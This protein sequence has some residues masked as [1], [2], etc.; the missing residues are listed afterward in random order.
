MGR[1]VSIFRRR[2]EAFPRC[3]EYRHAKE[4]GY[5]PYSKTI[6]SAYRPRIRL[7]G[8]KVI[9]FGSNNYLSLSIRTA[10]GPRILESGAFVVFASMSVGDGPALSGCLP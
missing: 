4:L 9:N 10:P 5:W 2:L 7:E 1:E 8:H 6:E 3:V